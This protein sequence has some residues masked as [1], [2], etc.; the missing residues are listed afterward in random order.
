ML[1][2]VDTAFLGN[3]ADGITLYLIQNNSK[4]NQAILNY[5]FTTLEKW[6]YQNY[7]VLNPSKC[8]YMCL[9]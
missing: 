9:G 2:V 7:M 6:F 1:L 5:N 4:S 8:F 3:Y